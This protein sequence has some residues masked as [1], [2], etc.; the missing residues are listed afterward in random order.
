MRFACPLLF[1]FCLF[2]GSLVAADETRPRIGDQ[3][4][5]LRFK[6]IR[7]LPRS[8][9]DL[10]DK[11]AYVFVFTTT[12]CPIV[13][14][15]LPRLVE[16]DGQ[17]S[18]RGVQFVAVNVGADD[19]IM[20]MAAQGIDCEAK[21]P[22]V[23]DADLS[24]VRGLGVERTPTLVILDGER[25]LVYRGR[26]DDQHRLGGARPQPSRHDLVEALEEVLSG[27]P[28]SVA[29]TP[30]D[31][32][33]ITPPA[34]IAESGPPPTFH[35]DVAAIL[36]KRC[37]NCH[38]EGTAAPFALVTYADAAANAEMIAEVVSDGRMPPWFANPKHGTFQNAPSLTR[39]ERETLVRWVRTGRAEGD[40]KDSP[41]APPPSSTEW[42]IGEPDRV[43]TT[44]ETYDIP[45]TGYVDYIYTLL[46]FVAT[47][48]TWVEA[49]EIKPD[50]LRVVH[51][52]NMAYIT[53]EGGGPRSFIT[54][55]V[56]GGQ[57]LDAGTFGGGAAVLVPQGSM[58]GLEIHFTTTGRPEKCRISVGLRFPR[59]VVHQRIRHFLHDPRR[60]AI[61]PGDGAYAVRTS[62]TFKRDVQL[63]GLFAH[64]HLRGKD[65]TFYADV[66][67]QG[68]ETLLQI[69]NYN[70]DWQLGYEIEPETKR[71]PKGTVIESLV[72]FDNSAFNPYNPDATR[73]VPYGLQTFDEMFNGF[74]FF[75]HE[76]EDLNLRVDPRTGHVLP[77]Q[78]AAAPDKDGGSAIVTPGGADVVRQ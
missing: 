68:R 30:V 48:D 46:P 1:I 18:P 69:P 16:L 32:C 15:I 4:A 55:H 66:P 21:F 8:L 43:I 3:I 70:F 41:P 75:I 58:L 17:Y 47:E 62:Y 10:G 6:D 50:N 64:M 27:R 60:L 29:E 59:S 49:V 61:T 23:K 54:G 52:C 25:R 40:P 45:A 42:R 73:T 35:R 13:Q 67:G 14:K 71:L 11:S 5:D 37:T 77:N 51:H 34:P 9:A 76:K 36:F 26:L 65:A 39:Q 33:L 57:P 44:L 12:Q 2:A 63:L 38:R 74:G 20:E 78:A 28:V 22:L 56:P 7:A 31:G 53:R 24:C 19:S 72:H